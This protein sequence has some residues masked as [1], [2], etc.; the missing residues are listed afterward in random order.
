M[1]AQAYQPHV[2]LVNQDYPSECLR[3]SFV[4][5]TAQTRF[6]LKDAPTE[7]PNSNTGS[8]PSTEICEKSLQIIGRRKSIGGSLSPTLSEPSPRRSAHLTGQTSQNVEQ[9]N[10]HPRI[11]RERDPLNDI[12]SEVKA[13]SD[14]V[15]FGWN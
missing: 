3:F 13:I 10:H 4:L 11:P 15:C 5:N 6:R 8:T 1:H 7:Q 14:L 9:T 12:I 2:A